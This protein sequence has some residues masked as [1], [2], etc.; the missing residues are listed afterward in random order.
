MQDQLLDTRC[1]HERGARYDGKPK[2]AYSP[3]SLDEVKRLLLLASRSADVQLLT[4]IQVRLTNG[5]R[6]MKCPRQISG[7]VAERSQRI[8]QIYVYTAPAG[9]PTKAKLIY[10]LMRA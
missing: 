7:T 10:A 8:N 1:P 3:L 6:G 4:T 9:L 2:R 5:I